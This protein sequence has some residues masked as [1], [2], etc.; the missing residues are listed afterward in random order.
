VV[1]RRDREA[2][3]GELDHEFD[4]CWHGGSLL[5]VPIFWR[6]P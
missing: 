5:L 4:K 2:N 3:R 1:R 6:E